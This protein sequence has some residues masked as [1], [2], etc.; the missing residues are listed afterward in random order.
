MFRTAQQIA[1][2][3]FS[4]NAMA[5][6]SAQCD[7]DGGTILG[8]LQYVSLGVG[9]FEHPDDANFA[10]PVIQLPG[11]NSNILRF[12]NLCRD[13]RFEKN[14]CGW[15]GDSDFR[16]EQARRIQDICKHSA[17]PS[18]SIRNSHDM[19]ISR[20]EEGVNA[21]EYPGMELHMAP[22]TLVFQSCAPPSEAI[23]K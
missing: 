8:N 21:V 18:R 2:R 14:P 19:F 17:D 20:D 12:V 5:D 6:F 9:R 11:R 7:A 16:S 10:T 1:A 23:N 4:A 22:R 15:Q 13:Y 3:L